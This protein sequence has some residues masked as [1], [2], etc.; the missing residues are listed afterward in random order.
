MDLAADQAH[1]AQVGKSGDE[2][3]CA[4]HKAEQDDVAFTAALAP[5]KRFVDR[6]R[7]G[8]VGHHPCQGEP[9]E[10]EKTSHDVRFQKVGLEKA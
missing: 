9:E 4:K 3:K 7:E 6:D 5:K 8:P 2:G 10:K 1:P